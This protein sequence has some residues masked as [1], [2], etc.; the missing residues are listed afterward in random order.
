MLF[1]ACSDAGV[2]VCEHADD[3]V[4]DMVDDCFIVFA[5]DVDAEFLV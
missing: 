3:A 4:D 1:F 2:F 5:Y